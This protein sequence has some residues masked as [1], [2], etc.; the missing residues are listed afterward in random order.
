[1]TAFDGSTL[2]PA[3]PDRVLAEEEPGRYALLD[4]SVG[5]ADPASPPLLV[6]VVECDPT[7]LTDV[8]GRLAPAI[9]LP[10]EPAGWAAVS[11]LPRD[12]GGAVDEAALIARIRSGEL[13]ALAQ[14]A[15]GRLLDIGPRSV[16]GVP[17]LRVIR[18]PLGVHNRGSVNAVLLQADEG[19]VLVDAGLAEES[20]R[21]LRA[22]EIAGVGPGGLLAIACTH[23]HA[24]HIGGA[25]ALRR[26]GL[27]APGGAVLLGED[28]ARLGREMFLDGTPEYTAQLAAN[29]V[30][31]DELTRWEGDL[32]VMAE[33]ADWPTEARVVRD[34]EVLAFVGLE[35]EVWATP[36]H[37]GDHLAFRATRDGRSVVLLGD[38]TLGRA[39]PH[40]GVRDWEHEDPIGDMV[41]SWVRIAQRAPE[42]LGVPAHGSLIPELGRYQAEL[43][44]TIDRAVDDFRAAH[45]G[46][47]VV[48]AELMRA[49]LA[50]GDNW[51]ARMFAFY[52][53]L[54][55]LK[56]LAATGAAR[57]VGREPDR[58][59]VEAP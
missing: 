55:M 45:A 50:S 48:A 54:A 29:G 37:T 58:Y 59:Q 14:D 46:S 11:E 3:A 35:L 52:D 36:G 27:L 20:P 18:L 19:I 53:A 39:M 40:C 44:A 15:A 23:L 43:A 9:D 42:E 4:L 7:D 6:A 2:E 32:R 51:G 8:I 21:L 34:G 17:W 25:E 12:A 38:M 33:Q 10:H 47:E 5:G 1:V 30:P 22:L 57:L 41:A 49:S 56:R 26:S 31:A 13:V 28:T 16:A 24:D